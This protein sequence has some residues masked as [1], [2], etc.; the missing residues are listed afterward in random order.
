MST[1]YRIRTQGRFLPGPV[2][3]QMGINFPVCGD[4][5]PTPTGV[6][7]GSCLV[8]Q[9]SRMA[10][11]STKNFRKLQ[12]AGQMIFSPM[13]QEVVTSSIDDA[14]NGHEWQQRPSPA[15]T[16]S[17]TQYWIGIAFNGPALAMAVNA[18]SGPSA[19]LP[20][21][22]ASLDNKE[23]QDLE[24][25]VS[26]SVLAS[27]GLGS[28]NLFESLAEYKQTTRMFDENFKRFYRFF[29]KNG[30]TMKR[31]TPQDA[32]LTYRYGIKPLISDLNAIIAGLDKKVGLRR[33]TTRKS[34]SIRR[35]S[36]SKFNT[37]IDVQATYVVAQLLS[38]DVTVRGMAIDEFLATIGSNIGFT[39][40]GLLTVPWE[41]MR[42][43]F[44]LD[45]FVSAGDYLKAYAPAPGYKT[46]GSCLV[47]E[48][49]LS[50]LWTCTSTLQ[51][52]SN[53]IIRPC[54]G[55]CSSTIKTK[56]RAPLG[57]PGFVVRSDF[58]FGS[59]TRAAD[60]MAL[61]TQTMSRYFAD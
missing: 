50:S 33:D 37:G 12:A 48:R 34:L 15:C 10:D 43:S 42:F 40:K 1:E 61:L 60:A 19:P 2:V 3:T 9:V 14:G 23:I 20:S 28:T 51:N 44:V 24:T 39:V 30:P 31:M 17:G 35:S 21:P 49:V 54:T 53:V 38:D 45:W 29:K 59:L 16:I 27:R 13:S 32:W 57:G 22:S 6:T 58:R 26:T 4:P 11:I 55:A 46:I 56:G 7:Y 8:G 36:V 41:L 25:E 52:N 18:T 5:T 47:T